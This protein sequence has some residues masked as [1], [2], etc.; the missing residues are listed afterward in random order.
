MT[1]FLSDTVRSYPTHCGL[2]SLSTIVLV[3]PRVRYC[4]PRH[5]FLS[6]NRRDS[7]RLSTGHDKEN[8]ENPFVLCIRSQTGHQ[9]TVWDSL[10]CTTSSVDSI[11][12]HNGLFLLLSRR[13]RLV[14]WEL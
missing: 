7:L 11:N 4:A 3:N 9:F 8:V 2:S 10:C 14:L 5:I 6:F 13:S 1:S 12:D